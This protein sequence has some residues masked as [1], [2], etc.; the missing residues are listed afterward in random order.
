MS[1]KVARN[2]I[3][4]SSKA[5]SSQFVLR[6]SH[7]LD[8]ASIDE[9]S[10]PC[11]GKII[12]WIIKSSDGDS[13]VRKK[14]GGNHLWKLS[15]ELTRRPNRGTIILT[16]FRDRVRERRLIYNFD[17][18]GKEGRKEGR[19]VLNSGFL[20]ANK[21]PRGELAGFLSDWYETGYANRVA[22]NMVKKKKRKEKL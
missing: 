2:S 1:F 12:S 13:S 19:N 17:K 8:D 6:R 11:R 4:V 3:K 5:K 14:G 15:N 18:E 16:R 22:I 21:L 7:Q 10:E 20:S 9:V